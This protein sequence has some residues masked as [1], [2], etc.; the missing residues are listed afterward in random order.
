MPRYIHTLDALYFSADTHKPIADRGMALASTTAAYRIVSAS[1]SIFHTLLVTECGRVLVLLAP[2]SHPSTRINHP[3]SSTTTT[4]TPLKLPFSVAKAAAGLP[5][6]VL[7]TT[8][9]ELYIY[10]SC[11]AL[12]D[13]QPRCLTPRNA[14]YPRMKDVAVGAHHIIALTT[15]GDVYA[16]GGSAHNETFLGHVYSIAGLEKVTLPPNR[17]GTQIAAGFASSAIL[18]DDGTCMTQGFGRKGGLGHA[19]D[20]DVDSG[21]LPFPVDSV[22]LG[23][24]T[25]MAQQ[26]GAWYWAGVNDGRCG[27]P[28]TDSKYVFSPIEYRAPE[29]AALPLKSVECGS[30]HVFAVDAQ[31]RLWV[32]A[33]D[34][35]PLVALNDDARALGHV[36]AVSSRAHSAVVLQGISIDVP[37]PRS[38]VDAGLARIHTS[39]PVNFLD[40]IA[41]SVLLLTVPSGAIKARCSA[42]WGAVLSEVLCEWV[43]DGKSVRAIEP[44]NAAVH[45]VT[46]P[47]DVGLE[48][49]QAVAEYVD[50]GGDVPRNVDGRNVTYGKSGLLNGRSALEC[51]LVADCFGL[52]RLKAM[53]EEVMAATATPDQVPE[54]RQL[55]DSYHCVHLRRYC[56]YYDSSQ[57]S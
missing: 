44:P 48:A 6:S 56:D 37:E 8:T 7:L 12:H 57:T 53:A 40:R 21:V 47:L 41:R 1:C 2:S 20:E 3:H 11:A 5:F 25:V 50:C 34:G 35:H 45:T 4:P 49:L 30:A 42:F 23:Y 28:R 32:T 26:Q 16:M 46:V 27:A 54:L 9:G 18:L 13:V 19:A 51:L 15:T 31:Q 36:L 17:R 38:A 55:A 33:V 29:H 10:D 14:G 43:K 39:E 24:D 52:A 22:A